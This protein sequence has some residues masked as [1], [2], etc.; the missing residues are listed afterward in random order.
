LTTT[1]D[2]ARRAAGHDLAVALGCAFLLTLVVIS[3]LIIYL[4][5]L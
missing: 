2:D 1:G 4:W 3:V 5:T